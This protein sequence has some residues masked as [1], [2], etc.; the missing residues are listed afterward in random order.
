MKKLLLTII[1]AFALG[2]PVA[3]AQD[4]Q[5]A[6]L[7]QEKKEVS[8]SVNESTLHVKNADKMIVE[9]Y[10]LAG[11]KVASYRS[12]SPECTIELNQLPKGCYIV[13]IGKVARKVYLR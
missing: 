6:G 3:Q 12:E 13:K 11:V 1:V 7:E 5:R 10:N 2:M 4:I 8:I 9:I